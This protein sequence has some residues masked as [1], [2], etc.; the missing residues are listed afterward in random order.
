MWP[1]LGIVILWFPTGAPL[2]RA[3][4][5]FIVKHGSDIVL[6][7]KLTA[8]VLAPIVGAVVFWLVRCKAYFLGDGWL[9][10][11]MV[12]RGLRFHGFDFLTYNLVSRLFATVREPVQADAFR[13][14]AYVSVV[15]GALYLAA[16]AWVVRRLSKERALRA[17]LYCLLVFFG[18]TLVF[19]GYVECYS[20]LTV[21]MLLFV[22]SLIG[23]YRNGFPIWA[24]GAAFGLGLMFHLDALFLAPLL[25][26]PLA[27]PARRTRDSSVRRVLLLVGP[28]AA[29][30]VLAVV[31]LILQGYNRNV[32]HSDFVM[33]RPGSAFFVSLGGRDGLLS[34]R[35]WKDV[36]NLLLVLAPVPA[37]M[38]VLSS[39]LIL[40][41][42]RRVGER[43]K[44]EEGE[45]GQSKGGPV[46][47]RSANESDRRIFKLLLGANLWLLVLM[48]TLHMKQGIARDWDLFAAHAALVVLTSWFAWS[49]LVTGRLREELTGAA[50]V[51][52]FLLSVPWFWL[53]AGEARSI[54]WFED[55]AV[56]FPAYEKA[57]AHEELGKYYRNAGNSS[58]ALRQYQRSFEAFP[59][60][61]RFGAALGTF[62]YSEGMKDEALHTFQ[63]VLAVDS[64]QRVALELT[65]RIHSERGE[66]AEALPYA[67]KLAEIG[68]ERPRAAAIHGAA[69]ETL[70]LLDEALASYER[71]LP[72][73]PA[74]VELLCR[75][76]NVRVS[77]GDFA[78]AEQVFESA[79]R[80]EPRSVRARMGLATAV[81]EPIA[82]NPSSWAEPATRERI[83][84]VYRTLMQLVS[85]G[86]ADAKTL[87][88][89]QEVLEALS[90]PAPPPR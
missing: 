11:E 33:W 13:M 76:G 46:G 83:R 59:G 73:Y 26:L 90:G 45:G 53:N 23:Y 84:L 38:L 42:G 66:Y 40:R 70:G 30:L 1:A 85:E 49:K 79:L 17:L 72:G 9:H 48:S 52:A 82:R 5:R 81:W 31:I 71:A 63:Q 80:L 27:W 60:H 29:G 69:A 21:F 89:H 62:Q 32:F 77:K 12:S 18:P 15:S 41:K 61:G 44:S 75:I 34:W 65:A 51:V 35:H 19:M 28:I 68:Q 14:F 54:R 74:S 8:Y 50:V 36:L 20:I 6:D 57:Y 22:A 7:R 67:R 55:L 86:S 2:S 47:G 24:P 64:T 4:G 25:V 10:G 56:G 88:W 87:T 78:G 39:V 43:E 37:A 58:E 3:L 16:V